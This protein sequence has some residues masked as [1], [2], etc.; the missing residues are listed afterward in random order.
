[1]R[2][3]HS[4]GIVAGVPSLTWR[5]V[6]IVLSFPMGF[7]AR[8][9]CAI[10][11]LCDDKIARIF[12]STL[13]VY[14]ADDLGRKVLGG[15]AMDAN[16]SEIGTEGPVKLQLFEQYGALQIG[17][18]QLVIQY[19]SKR[20]V[21]FGIDTATPEL[22]RWFRYRFHELRAPRDVVSLPQEEVIAVLRGTELHIC[23]DHEDFDPANFGSAVTV[24]LG[25]YLAEGARHEVVVSPSGRFTA[26]AS[27]STILLV[28][29]TGEVHT[30]AR[31]RT[32]DFRSIWFSLDES[33]I[34]GADIAFENWIRRE[35]PAKILV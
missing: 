7:A 6:M 15:W 16:L 4:V 10:A 21:P 11:P 26:V 1:M 24:S 29:Q 2:L 28:D 5:P 14:Q 3:F 34:H 12:G 22:G 25:E 8:E 23:D 33:L 20:V 17:G 9:H 18:V 27:K 31:D 30:V 13:H 32:A 19:E 35:V